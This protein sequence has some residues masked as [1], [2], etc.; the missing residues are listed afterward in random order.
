M[1]TDSWPSGLR[2][3]PPVNPADGVI[4]ISDVV[5]GRRFSW[6]PE[7]LAQAVLGDEETT[8]TLQSWLHDIEA[9]RQR[10]V[11]PTGWQHW[12][13]RGWRPSD[14]YYVASRQARYV[15]AADEDASVRLLT[16]HR[17]I[18]QDGGPVAEYDHDY[19]YMVDLPAPAAVRDESV[20]GILLRRRSGRSYI[21]KPIPAEVLSGVLQFGLADIRSRRSQVDVS[22]PLSLLNSYGSAW[23]IYLT[24]YDV[25]GV[26]AGA[27]K[28]DVTWHRLLAVSLGDHRDRVCAL[29]QGQRPPAT[30][31]W[32]VFLIADFPRYQ[33][34]YRH[35][36]ALRKLYLETGVLSQEIILV[37]TA[38]GLA[39]L[40]TPAQRDQE[41]LDLFQLP[42]T[43][44][45]P[46]T[47]LTTGW[48]RGNRGIYLANDE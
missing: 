45:G 34:R 6:S 10:V 2:L 13:E 36:H 44:F 31:G 24:V 4:E 40:V 25:N 37:A 7:A 29:L 11:S 20:S 32:T 18:K 16:L 1:P 35:E 46:M 27:Y 14:Q 8:S 22:Q 26:P 9:A 28:Y 19:V 12:R 3:R 48:S 15:D 21:S 41:T 42:N 39:T 5:G 33:W 43:R 17:L 47:T 30:A 23:D 38:Y